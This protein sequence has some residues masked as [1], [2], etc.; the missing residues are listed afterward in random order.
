MLKTEF[1]VL[2]LFPPEYQE[3]LVKICEIIRVNIMLF[4]DVGEDQC[5]N[6]VTTNSCVNMPH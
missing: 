5:W 6:N 2:S 1:K 4:I 3:V